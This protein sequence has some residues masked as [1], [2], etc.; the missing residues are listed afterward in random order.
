MR[1]HGKGL[2]VVLFFFSKCKWSSNE[3]SWSSLRQNIPTEGVHC[4]IFDQS[5][6]SYQTCMQILHVFNWCTWYEHSQNPWG[7]EKNM[8]KENMH[9]K[10]RILLQFNQLTT[11]KRAGLSCLSP[12][13]KKKKKFLRLFSQKFVCV[14]ETTCKINE[15]GSKILRIFCYLALFFI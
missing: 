12:L 3:S 15:S 14:C 10:L 9:A 11:L 6:V 2:R 13:K 5:L 7:Q 1:D 4:G 8:T